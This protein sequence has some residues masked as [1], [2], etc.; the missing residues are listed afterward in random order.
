[1]WRWLSFGG[2]LLLAAALHSAQPAT[3]AE[4]IVLVRTALQQ[5]QP[6]KTLAKSLRKVTLAEK[7]T[8][9]TLEELESEGAGPEAMAALD[10]LLDNSASRPLGTSPNPFFSP[11]RPSIDEQKRFFH[12]VNVNAIHYSRNLPNF[13]CTEVV[14]RA[15]MVPVRLRGVPTNPPLVWTP[16]DVLTLKLTYFENRERYDLTLI[17]GKKTRSTYEASGGAISEGDFGSILIEIFSPDSRTKFQWDHWTHLRKRLTQVYSYR[18]AREN[19]HYRIGVGVSASDRRIEVAGRRGFVYADNDTAMVMRITGEA[20]SIP[21]GFPVLAQSGMLDYDFGEVGGSKFL[22]PLRSENRL[23]TA[24]ISFKNVAEFKEYRKFSGE[25]SISFDVPD[26]ATQPD[27]A[28]AA[29][30]P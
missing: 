15:Q 22:L 8:L 29:K 17:N 7:L 16:R 24:G 6:D 28:D 21:P 14:Q 20:E 18:T 25:S 19:S 5:H 30:K 12:E 2:V 11:P 26:A 13:I 1:M 4:L 23:K 27:T 10:F 3:V 9:R